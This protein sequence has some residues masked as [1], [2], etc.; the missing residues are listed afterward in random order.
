MISGFRREVDEI[1]VLLGYVLRSVS[2]NSLPTFRE[3]L[4]APSSRARKFLTLEDGTGRLSRNVGKELPLALR[5]VPEERISQRY[6]CLTKKFILS[7]YWTFI[8]RY[9]HY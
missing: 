7:M 5:N 4:P 1:R 9:A 6:C 3:N 8:T 2:G